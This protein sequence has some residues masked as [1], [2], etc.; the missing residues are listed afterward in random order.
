MRR[1]V[2]VEGMNATITFSL[3]KTSVQ[4]WA[5]DQRGKRKIIVPV[6]EDKDCISFSLDPLYKTLWYEM[7][8][9]KK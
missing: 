1:P 5:F 2:N 9:V 3:D 6:I 7:E 8:I 4:V